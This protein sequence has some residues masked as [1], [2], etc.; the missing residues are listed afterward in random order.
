M[1]TQM[2][3][4]QGSEGKTQDKV[5]TGKICSWNHGPEPCWALGRLRPQAVRPGPGV[6][7]V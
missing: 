2:Q 3:D 4:N 7:V 6:A 1:T 5:E